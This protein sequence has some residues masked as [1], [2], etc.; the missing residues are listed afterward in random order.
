VWIEDKTEVLL[1]RLSRGELDAALLARVAGV[2]AFSGAEVGVDRFVLALPRGHELAHGTAPVQPGELAGEAVLLLDDGH[3]FR[4]QALAFCAGAGAQEL[5]YRATSLPTL[6]QM[7]AGGAGVTLLPEIAVETER[8][9]ADL[10]IRT[11]APRE[12]ARTV[13]LAWRANSP[14][15]GALAEVAATIRAAWPGGAV[16]GAA[17]TSAR[18]ARRGA[19]RSSASTP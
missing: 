18:P 4:D 2:E 5:G 11:F 3:C 6:V 8:A 7:V 14:L 1:E 15:A 12:P 10:A 9:H 17:P 13:V 19:R 16:R